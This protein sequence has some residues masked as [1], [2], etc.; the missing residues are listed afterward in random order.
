MES[1]GFERD[2]AWAMSEENLALM[3]RAFDAFGEQD[4]A[5]FVRCM[6]PDVEFEPRLAGVEGSYRGHD[7]IRQFM[8]DGSEVIELRRTDLDEVRDLGDRVLAL[9]TFH[10][11]GRESGAE[12]A[13]PFA[14][15]GTIRDGRFV[16]LKDYGDSSEAVEAAGL[17][18]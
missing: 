18:E 16:K 4:V 8:A 11:R 13:T 14:L 5:G 12:D 17:S 2:T 6:D 1:S 9:G 3:N 10:I 15:L 7:G